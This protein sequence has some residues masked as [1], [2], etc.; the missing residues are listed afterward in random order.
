MKITARVD[1]ISDDDV[2]VVAT[3]LKDGVEFGTCIFDKRAL[4]AE[5][6]DIKY[7]IRKAVREVIIANELSSAAVTEIELEK[8]DLTLRG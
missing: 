4:L 3:I 2:H 1:F 8:I 5:N 7:E 6:D